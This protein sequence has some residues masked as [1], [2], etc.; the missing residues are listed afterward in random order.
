MIEIDGS[1]GEGGG[2]IIRTSLTL[3]AITKK[4][5]HIFNIRANRSNPGLQMQ[6]LTS[7]K[8]VR[9][10]CRGTLTGAEL[11]SR[12]LTFEPGEII[13]GRY[14]FNIGTAGSTS[15]VAQTVIPI[16]IMAA[17]PSEI[18]IQGGTHVMK[19]PS[20]DYLDK[21]FVPAI[22]TMGA[23]VKIKMRR[24]G[25]YPRGGGEILVEVEPSKLA[26]NTDW[27]TTDSDVSVLIRLSNLQMQIAMHEKKIFVEKNIERIRVIQ[28]Q[29]LDP[30]NAILA[31]KGFH[32]AYSLGEKSKRAELVAK[33]ALDEILTTENFDVDRH[34]ADQLLI[35]TMLAEGKTSF[36]T[37]EIN[38]H[39]KTNAEI[40]YKFIDRKIEIN[41]EKKKAIV[42]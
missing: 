12:E 3:S 17:K 31:W 14:D 37:T 30:G 29:A 27:R 22:N 2:Q 10:I 6:H 1:H 35:Y 15:L 26:G 28:E 40:A 23:K 19:S 39:L 42:F 11:G 34:L 5:V 13:G 16:A 41:N 9:S 18:T 20:Y 25:Y 7:A 24:S 8:A 36:T 4:S 38:K 33:E 21:V 32:G